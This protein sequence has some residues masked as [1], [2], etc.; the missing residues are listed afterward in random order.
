[1]FWVELPPRKSETVTLAVRVPLAVGVN[2]TIIEQLD[3]F[4]RLVPQLSVWVK[5]LLSAPV[6]RM[7]LIVSLVVALLVNVIV[8][9]ALEVPT[10]CGPNVKLAG[11]QLT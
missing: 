2:V 4:G 8:C 11:D 10:V 1:M 7:L 9:V 3:C 5:S 6:I